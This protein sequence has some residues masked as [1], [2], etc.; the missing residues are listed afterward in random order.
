MVDDAVGTIA[1]WC[2]TNDVDA[3]Y[4]RAGYLRVSASAA[5]DGEWRSAVA[6]CAGLGVAEE[7]VELTPAEIQARCASPAMRGGAL[8]PNA[9]TIQPARLARGLRRAL[10]ARGVTFLEGTRVTRLRPGAPVQLE[11]DRGRVAAEQVILALNAWAAG[12][13]DFATSLLAWGSH[14]VLTEPIPG[15]LAELGWTGGEAIAD[16]RFTVH[17]FRTTPDGRLAFGAGVGAAGFGGRVDRRY[18]S[19]PRA[20]E[21]ARASLRR[22]FPILADVPIEDAWGGPIDI[23]PD[24]LPMI[25][26]RHGGRVHFAHGYSGNG[27]APAVFA[28]RVLAGLVDEPQ[29]ELARLPIVDRRSARLPA[30]A[31]ALRRRARGARGTDPS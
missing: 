31:R 10:A 19:D 13:R 7:Y 3:W 9:A 29:G 11:T 21:R 15:R 6:A 20:E 27:V 8:M 26:S 5:Q 28:G 1:D 22:F 14:I 24:R 12:W 30:G 18:D 16:A 23:S 4:R 17:Y 2:R 25:G